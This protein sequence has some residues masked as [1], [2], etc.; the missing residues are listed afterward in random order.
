MKLTSAYIHAGPSCIVLRISI[1]SPLITIILIKSINNVWGSTSFVQH[2]SSIYILMA[3]Y[4]P[5]IDVLCGSKYNK[6]ITIW[7]KSYHIFMKNL[8]TKQSVNLFISSMLG[9][10]ANPRMRCKWKLFQSGIVMEVAQWF[11]H[12]WMCRTWWIRLGFC[13]L[14]LEM[15]AQLRWQ[16]RCTPCFQGSARS[17]SCSSSRIY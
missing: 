17:F 2:T 14:K 10:K 1:G 9:N 7:V 13:G 8:K 5:L 6:W 4:L 15:R 3:A 12:K 16:R 11:F